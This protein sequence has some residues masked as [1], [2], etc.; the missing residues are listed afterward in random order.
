MSPKVRG[1]F[2]SGD[3]DQL[4]D[5]LIELNIA[6]SSQLVSLKKLGQKLHDEGEVAK[7]R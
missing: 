6:S 2:E 4:A 7:V 1:Q 3:A 5:R